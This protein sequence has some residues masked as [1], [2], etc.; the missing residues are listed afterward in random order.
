MG[1]KTESDALNSTQDTAIALNTSKYS[2]SQ[3]DTLLDAKADQ[4]TTYTKIEVI[5]LNVVQDT[6]V[7]LN[8]AKYSTSQVDTLLAAKAN[9]STTYTKT[10]ANEV[11]RR[12]PESNGD[13][14]TRR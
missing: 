10:E 9:Q 3:T 12:F 7:S 1:T 11:W 13:F 8:T 5:A 14:L 4:S 6:L 2:T